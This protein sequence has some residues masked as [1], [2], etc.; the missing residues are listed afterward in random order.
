MYVI[1]G[2]TGH[3]GTIAAK[4]L[5]SRGHRV[6]TLGRSADRLRSLASAG[7]EPFVC[8]VTDP[9]KLTEALQGAKAVYAIVPPDV[10]S[11]DYRAHQ[12][13]VA[14]AIAVALARTKSPIRRFTQQHWCRP[15][16]QV[17]SCGRLTQL[18]AKAEPHR[19]ANVLHQRAAYFM[20][21][22][23]AQVGAIQAMGK[24]GGPLRP[25][26]KLPMIATHDIG[27]AVAEALL[28]LDFEGKQTRELQG[29]RDLPMAEAMKIVG[30]A[31]GKPDLAYIQLPDHQVRPTMTQLGISSNFVDLILEMAHALN[32]GYMKA[33]EPRTA[34]HTTLSSLSRRRLC[35]SSST[36]AL[37]PDPKVNASAFQV[38]QGHGH[39]SVA[40]LKECVVVRMADGE[41][42]S[43]ARGRLRKSSTRAPSEP[44]LMNDSS[45]T[46]LPQVASTILGT[47]L[48]LF[49]FDSGQLLG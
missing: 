47:F 39:I 33:L 45:G 41:V 44:G 20:E 29:Q 19:R 7:A 14:D 11:N 2:A 16:G 28:Q 3:T 49:S 12:E 34:R 38:N 9:K 10:T 21:N 23:L 18:R 25:D 22:T 17:R 13:A 4:T 24:G 37:Q 40:F 43:Y 36:K 48:D 6:R 31:I 42:C 8:D 46:F 15:T 30:A 35:L 1:T 32:T 26:L 27:A 5:L